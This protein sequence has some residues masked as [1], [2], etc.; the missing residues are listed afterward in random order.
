[1]NFLAAFLLTVLEE[2]DAFWL[3]VTVIDRMLPANYYD[4]NLKGIKA[5]ADLFEVIVAKELP[6]LNRHLKNHGI[7]MAM[8][9]LDW[10]VSLFTV[11]FRSRTT[12]R[13]WDLFLYEG[14]VSLFC[15]ALA[16]VRINEQ[17][18]LQFKAMDKLYEALKGLAAL[19]YNVDLIIKSVNIPAMSTMVKRL[20]FSI[21]QTP[22]LSDTI[23][24]ARSAH[25]T[26]LSSYA[27]PGYL[28]SADARAT[29]SPATPAAS[30]GGGYH[31]ARRFSEPEVQQCVPRE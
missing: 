27:R 13:M 14:R 10:F 2:E 31:G 9:T 21:V 20:A 19:D 16:I 30:V 5:E 25:T 17:R 26:P 3:L 28:S 12:L 24:N 11:G 4:K 23:S 22:M 8:F 18:L 15:V 7:D 6:E 29:S 1:M